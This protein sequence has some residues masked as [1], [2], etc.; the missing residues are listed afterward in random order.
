MISRFKNAKSFVLAKV[1]SVSQSAAGIAA[2]LAVIG[3]LVYGV[4]GFAHEPDTTIDSPPPGNFEQLSDVIT[5]SEFTVDLQTVAIGLIAPNW[6][7]P[8][9][10]VNDHLYVSDQLGII[11][12]ID[13]TGGVADCS[14]LT[15]CK[16]FLD[17]IPRTFFSGERGLLGLAFHPNYVH[18]GLLYT[19]TSERIPGVD[20][21]IADHYSVITEWRVFDSRSATNIV[22]TSSER[23]LLRIHQP[24]GN[25][26]GGAIN[27]GIKTDENNLYISLGDGGNRDDQNR[28]SNITPSG[29]FQN[30]R[31][32]HPAIGNGQDSGT[33][34]GT[35]LR[36]DPLGSNSD[37]GEYGIPDDN[38]FV[39]V[40]GSLDEIYAYGLRNPF[41]FSFDKKRGDLY[42]GDVGQNDIEEV[43]VVVSGGNYGWRLKEGSFFFDKDGTAVTCVQDN[44]VNPQ[45]LRGCSTTMDPGGL[46]ADLIDPVAEYDTHIDGHS[47][48]GGFVYR[49][50]NKGL[51]DHKGRY[52]F[53]EFAG[54]RD[55]PRDGLRETNAR[56]L[57]LDDKDVVKKGIKKT[58]IKEFELLFDGREIADLGIPDLPHLD[59]LPGT[60][61]D[62]PVTAD[63]TLFGFGQDSAGELYV[64]GRS[65]QKIPGGPLPLADGSTGVVLR[66]GDKPKSAKKRKRRR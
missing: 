20:F 13:L 25:H 29:S 4:V 22:D 9:P 3:T 32:G 31:F 45:N 11:W 16:V 54:Y 23:V 49:G 46:P 62:V 27:F 63:L 15:D 1:H 14:T 53:A 57:H 61:D 33:I 28:P 52:I 40:E 38:P 66:I 35:I 36:I 12:N 41:R 48:I 47:V 44:P 51:K 42:V 64:M 10:G 59:L 26:N 30:A 5:P 55:G 60:A 43:D 8:A 6:G 56:L 19:Y 17:I 34:L 24:Q 50:K 18:N 2:V 37:N 7:V 58:E 21:Q 65:Q 39:N